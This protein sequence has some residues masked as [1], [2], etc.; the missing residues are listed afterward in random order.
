MVSFPALAPSLGRNSFKYSDRR[1]YH[2]SITAA[3]IDG[4]GGGGG[5]FA[6]RV[7]SGTKRVE[8]EIEYFPT[9]GYP[10]MD[11]AP[12]CKDKHDVHAP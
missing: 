8:G 5:A 9:P 6:K 7:A 10:G 4:C 2:P 3:E 12:R 11:V 1:R